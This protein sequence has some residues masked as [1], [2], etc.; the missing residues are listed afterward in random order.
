MIFSFLD[1]YTKLW[2][3]GVP[4]FRSL[5]CLH[6]QCELTEEQYVA[7]TYGSSQL[8]GQQFHA[9]KIE[10]AMLSS[11]ILAKPAHHAVGSLPNNGNAVTYACCH[12]SL[13]PV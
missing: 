5:R 2:W 10:A 3:T 13:K 12:K 8:D 7:D 6:L 9:M 4:T 1:D 11:E